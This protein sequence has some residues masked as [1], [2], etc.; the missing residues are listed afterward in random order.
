MFTAQN[1]CSK[2]WRGQPIGDGDCLEN[3]L[4]LV[5]VACGFDSHPLRKKHATMN[6][7]NIRNRSE[8]YA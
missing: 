2:F 6:P 1:M 5:K 3:S 8:N 7:V 4:R